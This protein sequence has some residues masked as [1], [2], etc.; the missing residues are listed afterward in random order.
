MSATD[1]VPDLS[2]E[3]LM[4]DS[5]PPEGFRCEHGVPLNQICSAC[6]GIEEA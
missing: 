6:A 3:D 5:P 1:E 4:V 2:F